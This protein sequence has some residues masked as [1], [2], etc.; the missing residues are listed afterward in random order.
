[1]ILH[2]LEAIHLREVDH[3]SFN[4]RSVVKWLCFF[5]REDE[6]FEINKPFFHRLAS[7]TLIAKRTSQNNVFRS[8]R[9][10]MHYWNHV[11]NV[12]FIKM[13]VAPIAFAMLF[14]KLIQDISCG[15]I[16]TVSFNVLSP[17]P[18]TS[19]TGRS[20]SLCILSSTSP[21][22]VSVGFLVHEFLPL[23]FVGI[24]QHILFRSFTGTGF[25]FTSQSTLDILGTSFTKVFFGCWFDLFALGT[26]FHSWWWSIQCT[27]SL[28]LKSLLMALLSIFRVETF[29]TTRTQPTLPSM[30]MLIISRFYLVAR[31]A[32]L[33]SVRNRIFYFINI[34]ALFTSPIQPIFT[35]GESM[36]KLFIRRLDF[37]ACRAS[38]VSHWDRSIPPCYRFTLSTVGKESTTIGSTEELGSCRFLLLAGNASL[39]TIWNRIFSD[40]YTCTFFAIR[41]KTPTPR[42]AKENASLRFLNSTFDAAFQRNARGII[43][44]SKPP[45]FSHL[46]SLCCQDGKV[47]HPFARGNYSLA[48]QRF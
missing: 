23:Y 32:L 6:L 27:Y 9:P 21:D 40:F 45:S 44:E 2:S 20:M 37:S 42:G 12:V 24:F 36:K 26:F 35:R 28:L 47:S 48:R 17:H 38:L 4:T 13:L 10:A 19:I 16:S 43:H 46:I 31:S 8:V 41:I 1:V 5:L 39:V 14:I 34:A 30:I 25:A 11:I 15:V 22:G 18:P 7:F 29:F 33:M 3:P